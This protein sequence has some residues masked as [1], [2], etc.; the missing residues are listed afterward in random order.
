MKN[1]KILAPLALA[2]AAALAAGVATLLKKPA[3]Q[4]VEAAAPQ[5]DRKSVV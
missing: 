1:T 3:E 5:A 4:A 2:A